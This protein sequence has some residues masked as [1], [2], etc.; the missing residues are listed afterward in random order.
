MVG[1][2]HF[3]VKHLHDPF[4]GA[5]AGCDPHVVDLFQAPGIQAADLRKIGLPF[6]P[7]QIAQTFV[8]DRALAKP[9]ERHIAKTLIAHRFRDDEGIL[10]TTVEIIGTL[11]RDQPVV[12]FPRYGDAPAAAAAVAAFVGLAGEFRIIFRYEPLFFFHFL[13]KLYM[14]K[15]LPKQS[16]WYRMI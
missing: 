3:F 10:H 2:P 13:E 6:L 15:G 14:K 5:A 11:H 7:V 9:V 1:G 12:F 16:E 4:T 8:M